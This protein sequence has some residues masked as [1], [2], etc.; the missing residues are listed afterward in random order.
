MKSW[1]PDRRHSDK[2]MH[3]SRLYYL[4]LAISV[5]V[6]SGSNARSRERPVYCDPPTVTTVARGQIF[7]GKV[8]R[9]PWGCSCVHWFCQQCSTLPSPPL[10]CEWTTC[11]A[12]PRSQ[13]LAGD[14]GLGDLALR[15]CVMR[16]I[17]PPPSTKRA[18]S[19]FKNGALLRGVAPKCIPS[20]LTR[21]RIYFSP[22][23]TEKR[24]LA[25]SVDIDDPARTSCDAGEID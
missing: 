24:Y 6:C 8:C 19:K 10:A 12:L 9:G 21:Q 18:N 14:C 22:T 5:V 1:R 15:I 7:D 4:L 16:L 23:A 11:A 17:E 3:L 2:S 25:S 13:M 20:L